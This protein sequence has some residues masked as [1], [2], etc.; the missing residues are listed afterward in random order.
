MPIDV[1]RVTSQK[2]D[3]FGVADNECAPGDLICMRP[4]AGEVVGVVLSVFGGAGAPGASGAALITLWPD[5]GPSWKE[6]ERLSRIG[7]GPTMHSPE[8]WRLRRGAL[9]AFERGEIDVPLYESS[10]EDANGQSETETESG[11]RAYLTTDEYD[12]DKS[13]FEKYL[14]E[15]QE[16]DRRAEKRKINPERMWRVAEKMI[17]GQQNK[18][19]FNG[20]L[21]PFGLMNSGSLD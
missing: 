16:A 1:P 14:E 18:P 3:E 8:A 9:R 17:A 20:D 7:A 5:V 2:A 6:K 13:R 21:G 12:W 19:T 15:K 4:A 11:F 10:S